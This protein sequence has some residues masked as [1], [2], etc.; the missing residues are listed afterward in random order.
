M[1]SYISN[2]QFYKT[3]REE[4]ATMIFFEKF[5]ERHRN[6]K[7]KEGYPDTVT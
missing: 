6:L 3:V 7:R 2:I 1:F 4:L 5:T